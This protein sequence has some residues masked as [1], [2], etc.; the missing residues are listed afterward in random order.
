[1]Y[2]QKYIYNWLGICDG[3][4]G[5]TCQSSCYKPFNLYIS[6]DIIITACHRYKQGYRG[7]ETPH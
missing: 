6:V 2:F 1:M 5:K 3:K 7:T 4:A